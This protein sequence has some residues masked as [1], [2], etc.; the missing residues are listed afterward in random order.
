MQLWQACALKGFQQL[1]EDQA[2]LTSSKDCAQAK[3]CKPFTFVTSCLCDSFSPRSWITF[4]K[5]IM[6]T[7]HTSAFY[8]THLCVGCVKSKP[9]Q[10]RG[11]ESPWSL[12][13]FKPE[14]LL[15]RA[16]ISITLNP[17]ALDY[18]FRQP[19]GGENDDTHPPIPVLTSSTL[20]G[21]VP[22]RR[23]QILPSGSKLKLLLSDEHYRK[24]FNSRYISLF[25]CIEM[26]H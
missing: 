10:Q 7:V 21:L 3:Q 8:I 13:D 9:L 19:R 17:A 16:L 20:L 4:M 5:E 12:K 2:S 14:D 23:V 22:S 1:F 11:R 15:R 24:V 18:C 6:H 25:Y 26:N